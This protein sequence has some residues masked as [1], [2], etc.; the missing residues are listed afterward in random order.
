MILP[1]MSNWNIF[2]L[3]NIISQHILY[4]YRNERQI[5]WMHLYKEQSG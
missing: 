5:P 2:H 3:T 4:Y 1:V